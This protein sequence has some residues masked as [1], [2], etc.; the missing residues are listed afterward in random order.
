M[1]W[2]LSVLLFLLLEGF[3]PPS[4]LRFFRSAL[5]A[6]FLAFSVMVDCNS[7]R[8]LAMKLEY[9][10]ALDNKNSSWLTCERAK[11]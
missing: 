10:D 8:S 11:M 4:A 6:A 9:S 3:P 7:S 2:L 1:V 5:A